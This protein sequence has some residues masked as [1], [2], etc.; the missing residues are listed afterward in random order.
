M[1]APIVFYNA[2]AFKGL[3]FKF[4]AFSDATWFMNLIKSKD[5]NMN[6]VSFN[7][8][9]MEPNSFN[10]GG[11]NTKLKTQLI[12]PFYDWTKFDPIQFKRDC[13]L[14]LAELLISLI[15]KPLKTSNSKAKYYHLANFKKSDY[16]FS[17]K[18]F[19]KGHGL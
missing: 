3:A 11:F 14:H 6:R 13:E 15:N 10:N 4:I 17:L 8:T 2:E 1:L 12:I 16:L 19:L 9:V 7:N 18:P 5:L